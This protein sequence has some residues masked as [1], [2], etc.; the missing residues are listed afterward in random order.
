MH[1]LRPDKH[2]PLLS[3][4]KLASATDGK[5]DS[6]EIGQRKLKQ[7]KSIYRERESEETGRDGEIDR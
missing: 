6:V 2:E 7:I 3:A 1:I 5:I 4:S